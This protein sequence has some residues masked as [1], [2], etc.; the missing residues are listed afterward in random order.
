MSVNP[1]V[2]V[3]EAAPPEEVELRDAVFGERTVLD[4][5]PSPAT[6]PPV[7][8]EVVEWPLV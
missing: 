1:F 2:P 5:P 6:A 7:A 4:G 8:G 3:E